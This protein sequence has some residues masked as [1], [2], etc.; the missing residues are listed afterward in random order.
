[1]TEQ[2]EPY[3]V[4]KGG[5]SPAPSRSARIRIEGETKEDIDLIVQRLRQVMDVIE[6]S[7][8]Y[9]NRRDSGVRRYLTVRV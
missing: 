3:D 1:M 2:P 6:E 5:N 8:D 9:S 4:V 7:R